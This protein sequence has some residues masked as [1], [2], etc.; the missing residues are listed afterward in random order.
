MEATL[1]EEWNPEN[2]IKN[3]FQIVKG[4]VNTLR[5]MDAVSAANMSKTCMK[6]VYLAIRG[7]KTFE[8]ACVKWK[9]LPAAQRSTFIQIKTFF[10]RRYDLYIAQTDTLHSAGVANSVQAQVIQDALINIQNRFDQQEAT[11]LQQDASIS[12]MRSTNINDD[13]TV[14]SALTAHSAALQNEKRRND[15]LEAQI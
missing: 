8:L 9:L 6:Y 2:H 3:L 4:G 12:Q 7:T 1:L 5:Q 13:A 10:R 11:M 14:F 15:D